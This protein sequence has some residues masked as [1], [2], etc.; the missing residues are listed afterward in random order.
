M[1]QLGYFFEDPGWEET[2]EGAR[3]PQSNMPEAVRWFRRSAALE[4]PGGQYHLGLCYLKGEGIEEDQTVGLDYI[5]KAADQGQLHALVE[6]ATLYSRGVGV[7][8]SESD[9][10]LRILERVITFKVDDNGDKIAEAYEALI[11]RY[12][13]GIG[14]ERDVL[15]A[16][17]LQLRAAMAG[18]GRFTFA[19]PRQ[20]PGVVTLGGGD[21][22]IIISTVPDNG[23]RTDAVLDMFRLYLKAARGAGLSSMQIGDAC[24]AGLNTPK[25]L[26]RAWLWYKL[27][28]QQGAPAAA[29]A[30]SSCERAMAPK[31]AER[32]Q[33][34]LSTFLRKFRAI[35]QQVQT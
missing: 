16:A 20:H 35:A 6:L 13:H 15:T 27:A 26:T 21:L 10:P 8:R 11:V 32:A 12:E 4:W 34:E 14:T 28:A 22:S 29:S 1:C 9:Q 31:E 17:E 18:V 33:A 2:P 3:F 24:R 19:E 5:R 23:T 30:V 7:P 25:S